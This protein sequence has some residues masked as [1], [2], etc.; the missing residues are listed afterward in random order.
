M[1]PYSEGL[2]VATENELL[3][4]IDEHGKPNAPFR[5]YEEAHRYSNGL[6]RVKVDGQYGYVDRAGNLKV[7]PQYFGA[8][9]FDHGLAFVQMRQGI[10]YL[11]TDGKPVWKS[12]AR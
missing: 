10:A 6:A 11:G 7:P 8:G 2:A 3:G 4:W 1:E 9:D 12:A 5:K